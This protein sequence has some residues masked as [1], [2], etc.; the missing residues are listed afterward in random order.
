[1]WWPRNSMDER[2]KCLC[3]FVVRCWVVFITSLLTY[4]T[5]KIQYIGCFSLLPMEFILK[6][7]YSTRIVQ[8][9]FVRD[10]IW[11]LTKNCSINVDRLRFVL[12]WSVHMPV[13]SSYRSFTKF[14]PCLDPLRYRRFTVKVERSWDFVLVLIPVEGSIYPILTFVRT[15]TSC[16]TLTLPQNFNCQFQG[17]SKRKDTGKPLSKLHHF[18]PSLSHISCHILRDRSL[19]F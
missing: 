4:L 8:C 5:S 1:M 7:R 17:E 11:C 2:E 3:P 16:F 12:V 14:Q 6:L 9:E 13:Y 10:T 18:R 15:M 19:S